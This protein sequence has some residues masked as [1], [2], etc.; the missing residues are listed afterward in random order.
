MLAK[1]RWKLTAYI[2]MSI[3]CTHAAVNEIFHGKGK[4]NALWARHDEYKK[5]EKKKA[6]P[7][8]VCKKNYVYPRVHVINT[9]HRTVV[10]IFQF[11][12][13]DDVRY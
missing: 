7:Q 2:Q 8:S 4:F 1:S 11:M 12:S 13:D 9:P 5:L 10:I 3:P 6:G